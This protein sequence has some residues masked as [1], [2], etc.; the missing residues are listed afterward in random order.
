MWSVPCA[1]IFYVDAEIPAIGEYDLLR[2]THIIIDTE[3]AEVW[4]KHSDVVNQR[5]IPENVFA[6]VQPQFLPNGMTPSTTPQPAPVSSVTMDTTSC[7]ALDTRSAVTDNG[8]NSA[9]APT[10]GVTED[11]SSLAVGTAP[12]TLNPFS[13]SFD[14]P[15]REAAQTETQPDDDELPSHI[16]L[17]FEATVAQP[18]LTADVDKQFRNVLR[19]RANTFAKD[20]TDLGFCPV[21]QH[22]VDTGDL[23]PTKQ[24]P[25]RPPL[26]AGNA[27]DEILDDMLKTGV[28]EPS[29]SE[30]ASPVCLV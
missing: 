6:T 19:R 17:L 11:T 1:S 30:W 10:F 28:I 7:I 15:S 26:S 13:P 14:P 23:P 20:S 21:L 12:H 9:L 3:S 22:D 16:N 4:S 5:S 24:S 29:T 25:R 2:A 27:E 18:R 8:S